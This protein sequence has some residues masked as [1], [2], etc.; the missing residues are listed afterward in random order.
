MSGKYESRKSE[1]DKINAGYES[2]RSALESEVR[3][4]TEDYRIYEA[5][6][7]YF[8]SQKLI[9]LAF[10]KRAQE[11][12]KLYTKNGTDKTFR[13]QLVKKINEQ[14]NMNK[15]LKDKQKTSANTQVDSKKQIRLWKD[16]LRQM[17]M[18]KKMNV[19]LSSTANDSELNEAYSS[20]PDDFEPSKN[21]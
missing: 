3:S 11:E 12:I 2:N 18:K 10:Q 17:E 15:T 13:D 1:Y 8:N 19:G 9:S 16:L 6:F 5:R 21:R 14:E 4:L 20:I 7:H